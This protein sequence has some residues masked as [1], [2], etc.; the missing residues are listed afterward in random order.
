MST[1][2]AVTDLNLKS[3]DLTAPI[4]FSW[5]Y[6]S[7]CFLLTCCSCFLFFSLIKPPFLSSCS[8]TRGSTAVVFLQRH[9]WSYTDMKCSHFL[10]LFQLFLPLRGRAP[11][12]PTI[13][14]SSFRWEALRLQQ[15]PE[16]RTGGEKLNVKTS[17]QPQIN[18]QPQTASA[19]KQLPEAEEFITSQ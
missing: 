8:W 13:T 14:F 11:L 15:T 9:T 18:L 4:K 16:E 1:L 5:I 6:I 7:E 3:P 12:V 17:S 19:N 2:T 10:S